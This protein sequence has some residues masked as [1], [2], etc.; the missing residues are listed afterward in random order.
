MKIVLGAIFRNEYDYIIEWYSWHMLGGFDKFVVADNG[1]SDGT[2]QL[3]EAM[4]SLG[5]IDLIYQP[6]IKKNAQLVA[7]N[8][9]IQYAIGKFDTIV[10]IDADEFIV[11]ESFV[12]GA[13][14]AHL[15]ELFKSDDVG[16]VCINWRTFGS[17]GEVNYID[18]PVTERFFMCESDASSDKNKFIKSAS[19]IAYISQVHAHSVGLSL[20][21]HYYVNAEQVNDFIDETGAVVNCYTG[22]TNSVCLS[23]LR[24]NHYVIKSLQEFSEKKRL[25]G[26]VMMGI[27]H[28]PGMSYFYAHDFKDDQFIFPNHKIDKLK[29]MIG[30]YRSLVSGSVFGK[31]LRGVIDHSDNNGIS[32]WLVDEDG[33]SAGLCVNVFVNNLY[34]G[35]AVCGFYRHDLFVAGISK[36]GLS[37]F[38]WSHPLALSSG[39][40]VEVKVNG[41][42]FN[43]LSLSRISI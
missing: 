25:R 29:D 38:R 1:S 24:I 18:R 10:F 32:G 31:L 16:G 11:H 22:R 27:A 7:Y 20:G 42:R 13:E 41:N 3:L 5:F 8:R 26:D 34:Q 19:K 21:S 9:I 40:I 39:D 2:T 15:E 43:F 4:A 33:L 30:Y 36:D 23:P 6:I 17:S 35:C 12:D 37:E 14:R 28:D